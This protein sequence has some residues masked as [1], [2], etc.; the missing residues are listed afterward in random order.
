[1]VEVTRRLEIA[2]PAD[3]VWASIAE[4][5]TVVRDAARYAPRYAP[6][7]REYELE[8]PEDGPGQLCH[9]TLDDDTLTTSQRSALD[10][11]GCALRDE[12]LVPQLP[13]ADYASS[14]TVHEV[15][16][17]GCELIWSSRFRPGASEE[18]ACG[19]LERAL[20]DPLQVQELCKLREGQAGRES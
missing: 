20:D 6:V 18:E 15:A 8:G 13:L 16:A 19:F 17:Q 11:A 10:P 5:A 7:V 14:M 2:A 12:I 9:L 1:M 3:R 4:F